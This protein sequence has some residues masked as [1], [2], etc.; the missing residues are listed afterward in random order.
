MAM[1]PWLL[2]QLVAGRREEL[3]ILARPLGRRLAADDEPGINHAARGPFRRL[4]EPVGGLLIAV[5]RRLAGPEAWA[6]ALD[7]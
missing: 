5:G 2:K 7:Y 4:G 1:N 6:E 3:E